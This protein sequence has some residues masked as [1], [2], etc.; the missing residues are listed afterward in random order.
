MTN[1]SRN[2]RRSTLFNKSLGIPT[3]REDD[4]NNEDNRSK[5]QPAQNKPTN[6]K[7]QSSS[8]RESKL[9]LEDIE[10]DDREYFINENIAK[11]SIHNIDPIPIE[12]HL[13]N[14]RLQKEGFGSN[15]TFGRP[16]NMIPFG[17]NSALRA[18][19]RKLSVARGRSSFSSV[20]FKTLKQ[21]REQ[22]KEAKLEE[23]LNES[24][25][26]DP[27]KSSLWSN[28]SIVPRNSSGNL[29]QNLT[30]NRDDNL[31]APH[32]SLNSSRRDSSIISQIGDLVDRF[33]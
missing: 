2:K 26:S 12:E 8:R 13:R 16:K 19:S 31:A 7:I 27:K 25:G 33:M 15:T 3:I 22:K 29:L 21:I 9:T 5:I 23:K 6:I 20:V 1:F 14:Y 17:Q 18:N 30:Q 24:N 4:E 10:I 32:N 28:L 11:I